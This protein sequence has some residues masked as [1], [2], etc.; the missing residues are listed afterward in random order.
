VVEDFVEPRVK[1][2]CFDRGRGCWDG[3]AESVESLELLPIDMVVGFGAIGV[4][5]IAMVNEQDCFRC[6]VI[7]GAT[8]R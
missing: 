5:G 1:E 3:A 2:E 8:M 6:V 7:F 4:I